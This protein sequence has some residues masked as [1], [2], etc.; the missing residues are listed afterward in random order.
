VGTLTVLALLLVYIGV[1]PSGLLQ[2][3]QGLIVTAVP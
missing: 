2:I 3:I 1:Y